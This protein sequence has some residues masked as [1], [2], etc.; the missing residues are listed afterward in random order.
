MKI[1]V[2]IPNFKDPRIDRA[3]SSVRRQS[4]SDIEILVVHGGPLLQELRDI[5]DLYSIDKLIHESDKGIFDALNKG[6]LSSTGDII[7]LMGSDDYLSDIFV[8]QDSIKLFESNPSIDG[9]C[10]GCVFVSSNGSVIREWFPNKVS[11]RRIKNGIFPPHFSLFLK[12]EVY[13]L[14]G[15]FKFEFSNN[16]ATDII[17][18][19]DLA[20]LKPNFQI[21]NLNEHYLAME[22][23]GA[24]TG[25]YK[26]IIR[27]FRIVH[28]YAVSNKKYIYF[29]PFFSIIRTGSKIFQFRLFKKTKN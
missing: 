17:W 16:V 27:Q 2:V 28:S 22:Y 19:L 4:F 8:F 6:I 11:S 5:Y 9:V 7:Y 26:A 25:S 21:L 13:Q 24:S 18:L 23:G 14:V 1:S 12:K 15:Q 29:W 20:I 10:M 3:L